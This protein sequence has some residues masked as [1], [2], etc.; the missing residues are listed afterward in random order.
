VASMHSG[1]I[2]VD[3][4]VERGGNCEGAKAG[5]IV[6]LDGVTIM[7]RLNL[8]GALSVNA[9]SLYARNLF[10]FIELLLDAE[11]GRLAIDWEDEIVAGTLI[12]RD[13]ALVHPTLTGNGGT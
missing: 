2:V 1:A 5:E 7:G 11:S 10:A 13:G 9:S 4:A 8:A 12:A 6:E 3:L